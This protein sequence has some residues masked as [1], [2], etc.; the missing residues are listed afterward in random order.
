MRRDEYLSKKRT[1]EI[2][3]IPKDILN[4]VVNQWNAAGLNHNKLLDEKGNWYLEEQYWYDAE[5][6][7][8]AFSDMCEFW[9]KKLNWGMNP[10]K[11]RWYNRSE[12]SG[13]LFEQ[14]LF[15][16][17]KQDK[18]VSRNKVI[19]RENG[20]TY[21]DAQVYFGW[22][23]STKE[24]RRKL[25]L[26]AF[27]ATILD[28]VLFYKQD[29]IS[30]YCIENGISGFDKWFLHKCEV[31]SLHPFC[32][33]EH[34]RPYLVFGKNKGQ[35]KHYKLTEIDN[36]D[37]IPMYECNATLEKERELRKKEKMTK[38][39]Q[40]YEELQ[41]V[42]FFALLGALYFFAVSIIL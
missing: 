16:C 2:V 15:Y 6:T 26:R 23:D 24:W 9:R 13:F 42:I 17:V 30:P 39:Q 14:Y 35:C 21:K 12:A 5:K 28:E 19:F 1:E 41:A 27:A 22:K 8:K 11:K 10:Q 7:N 34:P 20:K 25:F 18:A 4:E 36:V 40:F 38:K 37:G 29:I 33:K 32:P 3:K 31:A